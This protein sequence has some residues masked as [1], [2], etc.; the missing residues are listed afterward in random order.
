M[1]PAERAYAAAAELLGRP[2]PQTPIERADIIFETNRPRLQELAALAVG[3]GDDGLAVVMVIIEV[4]SEWRE[5]AEALLPNHDWDAIRLAGGV[6]V[7]RGTARCVDIVDAV[8]EKVPSL[9]RAMVT[10]PPPNGQFQA[11][12]CV[13]GGAGRYTIT[14]HDE[15]S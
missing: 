1:T 5:L 10:R 3:R 15:A 9:A 13:E 14:Q 7:L 4:D 2:P 8:T 11:V 12:V 6:P